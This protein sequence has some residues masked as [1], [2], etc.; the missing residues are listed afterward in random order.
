MPRRIDQ[1]RRR[2]HNRSMTGAVAFCL[3]LLISPSLGQVDNLPRRGTLGVP[4]AVAPAAAMKGAG[5]AGIGLTVNDVPEAAR[6]QGKLQAKDIIIGIEGK[7]FPTTTAY[8]DAIR[9]SPV[10]RP[11]TLMVLRNGKKESVEWK[12]AP[13]QDE[14]AEKYDV[15]YETVKTGP[16]R[17]RTI[18]TKPKGVAKSPMLVWIQGLGGSSMD[19]PLTAG[20]NVARILRDFAEDGYATMRIEKLGIG[21]SEGDPSG[22]RSFDEETDIYRQAMKSLDRYAFVDRDRVYVFGHSM[23]GCHGPIVAVDV[24]VAGIIAYGTVSYSWLE[25]AIRAAREQSILGGAKG[26]EVDAR[27]RKV[28]A[29]YSA[30]YTQK[31]SP[32]EIVKRHP[33][34]KEIRDEEMPGGKMSGRTVEY[35]VQLNDKNFASYWER[36]GKTR[37]LALYGENDFVAQEGDHPHIATV[38]N[39]ANPGMGTY[40]KLPGIDHFF[41]KTTSPGDSLNGMTEGRPFEPSIIP[42]IRAWI[43][44]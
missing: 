30:L 16:W 5:I 42:A 25:W 17:V 40:L 27:V 18:L 8:V 29:W 37:V 38:V 24:P 21:D 1:A 12:I 3:S 13:K 22:D 43:E 35:F 6:A 36:L 9:H 33:E 39:A 44:G 34:L 41:S 32:D 15:M 11:V 4:V 2:T 23:G 20:N 10:G 14:V 28:V 26:S 7:E 19:Y 31:L